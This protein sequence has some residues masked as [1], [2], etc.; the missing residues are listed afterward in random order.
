VDHAGGCTL[1]CVTRDRHAELIPECGSNGRHLCAQGRAPEHLSRNG[2]PPPLLIRS[3]TAGDRQYEASDAL[4]LPKGTDSLQVD[5]TALSFSKPER[6]RFRYQLEGF[7]PSWIEAGTRRQSFY[8]NLRPGSYRFHVVAANEDGIWNMSGAAL[9]VVIPPTFVQTRTF[10]A[11]CAAAALMLLWYMYRLRMRQLT[12]QERGRLDARLSERERIARE[13]HDTLLQSVQGLTLRFHKAA[14]QV[15]QDS[16]A[17]ALID[18]ALETADR[19]FA[20]GRDRVHALRTAAEDSPDNL[21]QSIADIGADL[22]QVD[23]AA[24]FRFAVTGTPRPLCPV[25]STEILL[26]AREALTNAFRHAAAM[27]VHAEIRFGENALTFLLQ[28]DGRGIENNILALGGIP[29]H[30]G[31]AGM[32]ERTKGIQATLNIR[33][34]PK[35]GTEIE[36]IVPSDVAYAN[37][38]NAPRW[39]QRHASFI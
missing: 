11:L 16:P 31:L 25:A 9:N 38:T 15:P 30:W 17:R 23:A 18:K 13:L 27:S 22:A 35:E 14:K 7:D 4:R 8:T 5:Y 3:I 24:S 19:V 29:G 26:I 34:Q 21:Q 1:A 36:L 33:S 12:A 28:D 20:E 6:I 39:L 10:I 37:E 2:N 32:R